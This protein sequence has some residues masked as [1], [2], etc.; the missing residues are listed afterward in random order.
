ME[1]ERN[2]HTFHEFPENAPLAVA[3]QPP[4]WAGADGR[5][6]YRLRAGGR[7]VFGKTDAGTRISSGA[8]DALDFRNVGVGRGRRE[9]LRRVGHQERRAG[10][11]E[12]V[13][14]LT[15]IACGQGRGMRWLRDDCGGWRDGDRDGESA[16][17]DQA[18]GCDRVC[19]HSAAFVVVDQL[20]GRILRTLKA[21]CRHSRGSLGTCLRRIR[22]SWGTLLRPSFASAV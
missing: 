9:P 11:R 10:S 8:G 6:R 3:D 2:L 7:L 17:E 20:V 4:L 16:G 1:A 13:L 18:S 5:A 21:V 15:R 12:Y 19:R 14:F 22:K